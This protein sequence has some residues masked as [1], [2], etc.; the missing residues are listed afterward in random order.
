MAAPTAAEFAEVFGQGGK[1]LGPDVLSELQS[2][3]RLHQLSAQDLFFKWESY[4]I[5]MDMEGNKLSI[6]TARA[7][8]QDVQDALERNNR[9]QNLK[10]EKR[11]GGTPR[12]AFKANGGDVFGM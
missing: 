9:A 12:T 2:I 1:E 6:S 5:K 10:A 11:A 8:K 4:C 3:S 7:L